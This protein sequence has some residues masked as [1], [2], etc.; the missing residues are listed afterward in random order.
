MDASVR[1]SLE[2]IRRLTTRCRVLLRDAPPD[3][4]DRSS[5][6]P[7]WQ[8]RQ[9]V[10]HMAAGG[11]QFRAS[12][13][14]GVAGSVEPPPEAQAREERLAQLAASEPTV[15]LGRLARA[16]T[17]LENLY[18]EL[19]DEQLEAVC[20][21]RRGNRSARW[22]LEHRLAEVAFHVWDLE[23]SLGLEPNLDR[24]VA[25]RLLP[26]LLESNLPRTY[27]TGPGGTGRFLLR[28]SKL[29]KRAWLLDAVP[30]MLK[31]TPGEAAADATI[32]AP[33][34]ALGLLVYGRRSLADLEREGL[35][36]V[37]G[38]RELA[39]R[40]GEIFASP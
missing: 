31:V 26:T 30:G 7:P 8:V 24:E 38:D 3:V 16:T 11:E 20:F 29:A 25:A 39:G 15:I 6:C 23:R 17:A 22:Y 5:N 34:E 28:E 27:P 4:W 12:V 13:E 14:R 37:E 9:L 36:S 35:A 19:T 33:P 32:T 2:H 1:E 40:F 21:H 18:A 10:A